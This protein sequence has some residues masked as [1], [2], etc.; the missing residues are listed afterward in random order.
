M[1]YMSTVQKIKT[2]FGC[3]PPNNIAEIKLWGT[4]HVELIVP[5]SKSIREQHPDGAIINNN[6]ILTCMT[7]IGPATGWFKI[8][9]VPKCDLNEV[10]GINYEYICN[11]Y[12]RLIQLFNNTWLSKYLRPLKF[13]FDNGYEFKQYFTILINY[14]DI[15]IFLTTIK[16]P[17][18]NAPVERVHQLI[19]NI[20]VKNIF[21]KNYLAVY[22][23]GV[24]S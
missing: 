17:Q 20:L 8:V 7:T 13:V 23:H 15:K 11:S 3:L 14:F 18:N 4:F 21:L 2:I 10:I 12:Y 24:K 22:I 5:Y 6:G 1:Q 16:N 19:L 9:K